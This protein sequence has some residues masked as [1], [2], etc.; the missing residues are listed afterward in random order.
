MQ[1]KCLIQLFRCEFCIFQSIINFVFRERNYCSYNSSSQSGSSPPFTPNMK[2][3]SKQEGEQRFHKPC[4]TSEIKQAKP[5]CMD[6]QEEKK[7]NASNVELVRTSIVLIKSS[8]RCIPKHNNCTKA[9]INN[10]L[11]NTDATD[12][13]KTSDVS[14]QPNVFN[15][16]DFPFID[17]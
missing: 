9:V 12:M 8:E 15:D 5:W 4:T 1:I 13:K 16:I 17:D 14:L 3:L 10:P 11:F 2:H 6:I 7:T